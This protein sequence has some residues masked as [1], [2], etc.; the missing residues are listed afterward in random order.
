MLVS[1]QDMPPLPH[2]KYYTPDDMVIIQCE[3]SLF[4]VSKS[5][6]SKHAELFKHLFA[7]PDHLVSTVDIL[8]AP[9]DDSTHILDAPVEEFEALLDMVYAAELG[10]VL[11]DTRAITWITRLAA[12]KRWDAK[13]FYDMA[14]RELA[15]CQDSVAHIVAARRFDL[16]NWLWPAY[17]ALSLRES[18]LT[19]NEVEILPASNRRI[20]H[21]RY[22]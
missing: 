20:H 5:W 17:M 3:N 22:T 18:R 1:R 14:Y 16:T 21:H 6:L 8:N 12:A 4:R 2:C 9:N 19:L 10:L 7:C 15:K 11:D 13:V